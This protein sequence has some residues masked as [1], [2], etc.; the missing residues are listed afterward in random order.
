M[1]NQSSQPTTTDKPHAGDPPR[2]ATAGVLVRGDGQMLLTKHALGPFTGHWSMPLVGVAD[3][4]T[5]EDALARLMR[6]MLGVEPGPFEFLDTIYLEGDEGERFILNTFTCVDWAG[7][8]K[9]RG[10]LYSEAVW[11]PPTEAHA[12]D[13]LPE[14]R[15]WLAASSAAAGT[16]VAPTFDAATLEREL[17]DARGGVLAAFDAIAAARR[18]DDLDGGWS[19]L[20]VLSH[21]ADVEAYYLGEAKRCLT[22][23]ARTFRRFN[24]KQWADNAHL[25]PAEDETT[26]RARMQ[27]VRGATIGWLREAGTLLDAYI[28]HETRGLGQIGERIQGMASHDR[29]HIEQL[30]KMAQ[31]S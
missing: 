9:L 12:L 2:L 14:V 7:E 1:T 22:E 8:P 19:P 16:P 21:V 4:E 17:I 25:R 30:N 26:I 31:G 28:E 5:A 23:P 10:G 11:A 6:L 29:T 20:D 13:L 27:A 24:D 15:D 18:H 3:N